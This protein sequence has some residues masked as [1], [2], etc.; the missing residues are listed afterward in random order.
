MTEDRAAYGKFVTLYIEYRG[1]MLGIAYMILGD[2]RD[3]ED[4]VQKSFLKVIGILDAIEEPKCCRTRALLAT[5]TERTAID[6]YRKRRRHPTV[7][8]RDQH[9]EYETY[10]ADLHMDLA[11]AM[12]ALPVIYRKVL[13]LKYYNGFSNREI[14]ASLHMTEVNVRKTIQRAKDKLKNIL[15]RD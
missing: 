2:T 7:S 13:L 12:A 10:D 1:L 3:S 11:S 8:L 14:A 5:I 15:E 9:I 6:L 4:V